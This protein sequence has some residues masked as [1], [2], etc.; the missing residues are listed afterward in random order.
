MP[1]AHIKDGSL[2]PKQPNVS[3]GNGKIDIPSI[4]AA[5]NPEVFEWAIVEFDACATD[6]MT[7]VAESY[8]YLTNNNLAEGNV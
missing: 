7:A 3:A 5:V 8:Q 4:F 1:Y 2:E 6:M